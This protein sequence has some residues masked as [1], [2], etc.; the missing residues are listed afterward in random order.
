M[1]N[2]K[3]IEFFDRYKSFYETSIVGATGNRL[4]NRYKALIEKNKELI[5]D[6]RILDLAS[7]DG[8]WSFA[9][10]KN[11]AK[12]VRGIEARQ[13]LVKNT[14]TNMK[15]YAIPENKYNFILGDIFDEIIKI[16]R[17]SIDT[18]FCFGF[19]YHTIHHMDLLLKIKRLN[20]KY[21]IIDTRISKSPLPVIRIG[22]EKTGGDGQAIGNSFN[23]N[24]VVVG[25]PS[26]SSLEMMLKS[27]GFSFSYYDWN[28]MNIKDWSTL[29]DYKNGIRVTLICKNLNFK[30]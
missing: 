28:A 3:S 21:L 19:F 26:R 9:A 6:Q 11:G 7:H 5:K 25:H 27:I 12:Q 22:M 23:N 15:K 24:Q 2:D 13:H 30:G 10:L 18:V 1:T 29:E 20:P 8:R 14:I 16:K 4:N 17:N